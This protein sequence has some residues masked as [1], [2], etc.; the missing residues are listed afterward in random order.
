MTTVQI[1]GIV[2]AT[3][4]VLLLIIA[5][6]VTRRRGSAS[7]EPAAAHASFL[8]DAPQDTLSGLGK[9]ER[10]MEDITLDPG[11]HRESEPRVAGAGPVMPLSARGQERE[12]DA[13][14]L[15]WGPSSDTLASHEAPADDEITG[16]L[17]A[18]AAEESRS[19]I[20]E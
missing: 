8:D 13:L 6:L 1:V 12:N 3:A 19:P 7:D 18:E 9:A 4:I 5:L 14:G 10:P 2:V 16:E 15:D 20:P 17:A 11:A